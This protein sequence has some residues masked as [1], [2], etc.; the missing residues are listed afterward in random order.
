MEEQLKEM[1]ELIKENAEFI[2]VDELIEYI[3]KEL[4]KQKTTIAQ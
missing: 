4:N 1:Y 3:E 2:N